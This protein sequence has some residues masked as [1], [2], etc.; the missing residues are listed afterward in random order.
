MADMNKTTRIKAG[1]NKTIEYMYKQQGNIAFQ[2][3]VKS[4]TE[5]GQL[6]LNDLMRYPLTPVP[7]SIATADG[8]LAKTD[9]A[10]GIHYLTKD[11]PSVD[12]PPT[13][14]TLVIQDGNALFHSMK[15]IPPFFKDISVALFDMLPKKADIIFIY[16]YVS[17]AFNKKNKE[18]QHRGS[19]EKL[20]IQGIS[21]KKPADWHLFLMNSENKKQLVRVIYK[22][23]SMDFNGQ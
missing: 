7:Y 12:L 9:K 6:D 20:L 1:K 3:L 13:E 22:V 19:D 17:R 23:W 14:N 8:L 10:K 16:R 18:R 11:I 2:L 15:T 4:Q 21:T 5:G